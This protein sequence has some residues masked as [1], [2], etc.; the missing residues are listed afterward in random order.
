LEDDQ[1]SMKPRA[2]CLV[3]RCGK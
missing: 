3:P 1:S 2:L